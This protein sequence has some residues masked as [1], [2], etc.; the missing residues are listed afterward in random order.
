MATIEMTADSFEC[1]VTGN[2][3]VFIDFWASWCGPC[4]K[5]SPLVDQLYLDAGGRIDIVTISSEKR[6]DIE[7]YLSRKPQSAPVG[8]DNEGLLKLD[9]EVKSLP[10]IVWVRGDEVIAWDYGV[11]GVRRVVDRMRRELKI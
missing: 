11:G 4:K 9:Y 10:T 1:V 8:H 5:T 2:N 7:D 3:L 6:A